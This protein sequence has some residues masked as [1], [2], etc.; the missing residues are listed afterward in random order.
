MDVTVLEVAVYKHWAHAMLL[1]NPSRLDAAEEGF[2][3]R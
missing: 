3:P 1:D 2:L